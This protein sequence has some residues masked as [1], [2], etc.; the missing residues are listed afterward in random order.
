MVAAYAQRPS[1]ATACL[2]HPSFIAFILFLNTL[3]YCFY[4]SNHNQHIKELL[5]HIKE[6]LS[7]YSVSGLVEQMMGVSPPKETSRKRIMGV[8]RRRTHVLWESSF[9][10]LMCVLIKSSFSPLECVL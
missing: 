10:P 4:P 8:L 2:K 9:T 3:F 7:K 1:G 6:L 5:P